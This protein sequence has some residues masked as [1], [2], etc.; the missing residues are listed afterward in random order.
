MSRG[1]VPRIEDLIRLLKSGLQA[2]RGKSHTIATS[3]N[4]NGDYHEDALNRTREM[5]KVKLT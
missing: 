2:T 1:V 4:K 3:D 5:T